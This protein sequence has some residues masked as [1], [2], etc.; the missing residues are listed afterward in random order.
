MTRTE[1]SRRTPPAVR[2]TVGAVVVNHNGGERILRVLAALRTQTYPLEQVFVVDNASTDRSVLRIGSRF[3]EVRVLH[4]ERNAGIAIA[5]NAGLSALDTRLALLLDHDIYAEPDCLA[6]MVGAYEAHGPMVVCP[7]VRLLP[8]RD[9]VQADG[10]ALH[11]LGTQILH[12][13]YERLDRAPDAGGAVD[14]CIGACMLLDR[15]AVLDAGGF[16]ELFFFYFEDLEFSMRLR[17]RGHRIWCEPSALVFHERAAGTPLLSFRGQGAYPPARA[18]FTMRNRLLS[19]LIHYRLRTLVMLSPVLALHELASLAMAARKGCPAEWLRSW[20]WQF[21]H[22]HE[23]AERRRRMQRLR[24]VGDRDLLVG[25]PP[26][27]APGLIGT[28]AE[29]RLLALY[30]SVVNGYWSLTRRWIG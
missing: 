7:R 2:P 16:D 21:G 15:D 26:P 11:F 9:V 29:R 27:L 5:R 8:E 19:M 17:S 14:S 22:L 6:R 12:H 28:G 30:S 24:R 13:G 18:Y 10:A 25:G 1:G 4:L 20:G 3:P 23:I